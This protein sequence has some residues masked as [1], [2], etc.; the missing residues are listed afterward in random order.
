MGGFPVYD[1]YQR[2]FSMSMLANRVMTD[3]DDRDVLVKKLSW[4]LSHYMTGAGTPDGDK[5]WEPSSVMADVPPCIGDWQLVWGPAVYPTASIKHTGLYD[6]TNAAFIARCEQVDNAY[7]NRPAIYVVGVAATNPASM[8]DIFVQDGDVNRVVQWQKLDP[9]ADP[10]SLAVQLS[11]TGDDGFPYISAATAHGLH[12]VWTELVAPNWA[13][14]AGQTIVQALASLDLSRD[15]NG[16]ML[17]FAGHSLAAALTPMMAL[18]AVE[19]LE[20]ICSRFGKGIYAYPTAGA[21]PGNQAIVTWYAEKLAPAN[22]LGGSGT[23]YQLLNARIWNSLDVVPHAWALTQH[24]DYDGNQSPM[25]PSIAGLYK[26]DPTDPD[27]AGVDAIVN[28]AMNRAQASGMA[29]WTLPGSMLKGTAT[30][31]P[32][33]LIGFVP[34]MLHQ[35]IA[36]YLEG[37]VLTVGLPKIPGD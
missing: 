3:H 13:P 11:G 31:H 17:V 37:L 2:I 29:Y 5:K 6:A 30:S 18:Y 34:E 12:D 1:P 15:A 32:D 28:P 19:R 26:K 35:H 9:S 4:I 24:S 10:S 36:A 27:P 25:M 7:P 16:S 22:P 21:T 8:D 20:E 23:G 14:G 33:S